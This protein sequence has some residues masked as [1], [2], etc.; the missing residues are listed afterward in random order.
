MVSFRGWL[1]WFAVVALACCSLGASCG[2]RVLAIMPGVINNPS[3]RTLRRA[4]F[5][6]A[7]GQICAQVQQRSIPLAL[8]DDDPAVGRFFT[9]ACA[10]HELDNGNLFVQLLG[11]G[12]AWTNVT[13]RLGFE[14]SAAVEYDHD[15]LMDGSRMYVYFRQRQTQSSDLKVLSVERGQ[16]NGP[17]AL[18]TD[19]WGSNL[20]AVTQQVGVRI[21][22]NQLARGFT[23]V[24]ESDGSADFTL[25]LLAKGQQVPGPFSRGDSDWEILANDRTEL[26]AGQRDF[27]GPYRIADA[28]QALSLTVL[29]EGAP[30]VVLYAVDKPTGDLWI[31]SHE[32]HAG[33]LPPVAPPIFTE[34]VTSARVVPG[35]APPV[36]RRALRLPVGDY[37]LVFDNPVAGTP[38]AAGAL[39][40]DRAALVSYAVQR[41]EAQ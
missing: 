29:V 25:G 10:V 13:G 18:V 8:R 31:S 36:W 41:G 16:A 1:S 24:R 15:F 30:S 22:Q 32:R 38:P 37:Y 28:D 5:G 35:Q 20:Q 33:A 2:Q 34:R 14:A 7:T 23:V 17:V 9:S 11:H 26:H 40:D 21:L 4:I 6:F 3:N 19:L 39:S 12:Y 27:T